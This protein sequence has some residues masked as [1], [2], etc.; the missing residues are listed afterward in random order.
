M[1]IAKG[2]EYI[3]EYGK[4]K[5]CKFSQAIAKKAQEFDTN[6]EQIEK[7]IKEY[8]EWEMVVRDKTI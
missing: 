6:D 3:C 2:Y 8:N 1:A 7:L 4:L 5:K